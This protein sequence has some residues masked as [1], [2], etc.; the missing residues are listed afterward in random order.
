MMAKHPVEVDRENPRV[1]FDGKE[2][3]DKAVKA[4]NRRVQ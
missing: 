3:K 4:W 2:R 1:S